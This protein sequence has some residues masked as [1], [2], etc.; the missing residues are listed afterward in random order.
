MIFD[1]SGCTY[2]ISDL[3]TYTLYCFCRGILA[4]K[5]VWDKYLTGQNQDLTVTE[6][7]PKRPV[8]HF[9][10]SFSV[11]CDRSLSGFFLHKVL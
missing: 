3:S 9:S 7:D 6:K 4:I 2:F 10:P 8:K 5:I 11:T 1:L